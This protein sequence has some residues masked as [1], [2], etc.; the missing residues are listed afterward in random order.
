[1][2]MLTASVRILNQPW[3]NMTRA[4]DNQ[5]LRDTRKKVMDWEQMYP[6]MQQRLRHTSPTKKP[7]IPSFAKVDRDAVALMI[8]LGGNFRPL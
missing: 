7:I 8:T 2:S 4:W 1:M 6:P 3:S 5:Q